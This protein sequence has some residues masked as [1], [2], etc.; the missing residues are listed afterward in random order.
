MFHLPQGIK[1]LKGVKSIGKAMLFCISLSTGHINTYLCQGIALQFS[2]DINVSKGDPVLLQSNQHLS[3]F[4]PMDS[5]GV[6]AY[7]EGKDGV[8]MVGCVGPGESFHRTQLQQ[9]ESH[10]I[11]VSTD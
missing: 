10:G 11:L 8:Y 5:V 4:R 1:L 6:I 7:Y 9:S 2:S 3:T